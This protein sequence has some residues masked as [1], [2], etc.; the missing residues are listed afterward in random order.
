MPFNICYCC[1]FVEFNSRVLISL[2]IWSNCTSAQIAS[3]AELF[4]FRKSLIGGSSS[5]EIS[6]LFLLSIALSEQLLLN[7]QYRRPNANFV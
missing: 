1:D 3:S 6:Y 5:L 4:H 2:R 7:Y